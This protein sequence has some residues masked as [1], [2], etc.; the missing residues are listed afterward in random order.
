MT[1]LIIVDRW[2][3]RGPGGEEAVVPKATQ[4]AKKMDSVTSAFPFPRGSRAENPIFLVDL[5]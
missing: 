3:H 2:N 4:K 5:I 1:T